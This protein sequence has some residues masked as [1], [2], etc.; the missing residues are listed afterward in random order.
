MMEPPP[1]LDV[2]APA[3]EPE[4]TWIRPHR[5]PLVFTLGVLGLGFCFPLGAF[6]WSMGTNDLWEMRNGITDPR[7]YGPTAAGRLF[8]MA[9]V[10]LAV[11]ALSAWL[12][13]L[14]SGSTV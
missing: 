6:A 4:E 9:S 1:P 3:P 2:A 8:G 10:I 5:G 14:L 12:L 13:C 7:G 11:V